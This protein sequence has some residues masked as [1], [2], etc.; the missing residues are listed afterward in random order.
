MPCE[1]SRLVESCSH[2][3]GWSKESKHLWL[4]GLVK[5]CVRELNPFSHPKWRLTLEV[6]ACLLGLSKQ[7]EQSL[8]VEGILEIRCPSWQWKTWGFASRLLLTKSYLAQCN[9]GIAQIWVTLIRHFLWGPNRLDQYTGLLSDYRI[10]IAALRVVLFFFFIFSSSSLMETH[11]SGCKS[12][13]VYSLIVS[14]AEER[15]Q[16]YM[17]FVLM[18]EC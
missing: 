13:V 6:S 3:L 12:I 7:Q 4:W 14:P 2:A 11:S 1:N 18:A 17:H 8:L 9:L 5:Y 10:L 15:S 16:S